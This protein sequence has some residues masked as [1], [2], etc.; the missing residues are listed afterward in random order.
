MENSLKQTLTPAV[1]VKIMI[2]IGACLDIPTGFYIKGAYGENV[3][4]AG[5]GWNTGLVGT[6]N[7]YKSTLEHFMMLSAMDRIFSTGETSAS[8][9]DTE[10]NIHENR[11]QNFTLKFPSFADKEIINDGTWVITDKTVYLGDEWFED[12]KKFL[13]F[14]MENSKKFIRKTPFLMR[15]KVSPLCVMV[16]TFSEIDSLSEFETSDVNKIIEENPLGDAGGNTIH[17]R[18]GLAKTRLLMELPSLAGN[19]MHFFLVTGQYGSG[20]QMAAGPYAPPPEKK[21]QYMKPGEKIKGVPDKFFF[22]MSNCWHAVSATALINQSTKAAEYPK[23]SSENQMNG[24]QD[25]NIVTIKQ[26]RSKSGP[27]GI[28]LDIIVSQIEGVLP[29]LTEFHFIKSENRFGLEGS[30]LNYSL[31]L[32]PGVNLSRTTVRGKIDSDEKLRRAINI[33]SELCQMQQYYRHN[34]DVLCTPKELYEGVKNNGYDWDFILDHTRGWWTFD[35]D[36][37]PTKFFLSTMD[38]CL[39]RLGKYHP[40]WL[41][42]DKKTI[43]KEHRNTIF[44]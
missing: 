37:H 1:N 3:L 18:Q 26:L 16:P 21:M 28:S 2:N 43:K 9:Y 36:K 32:Y 23:D 24:D 4:L 20:I 40:Y 15:D 39:M 12:L 13:R 8:T 25:L 38:L 30:N 11:L 6:G 22:L 35:N 7:K 44:N 5:L 34:P 19:A 27:S 31:T 41:E 42:D 10:T 33:T 14:K 17:M 29:T